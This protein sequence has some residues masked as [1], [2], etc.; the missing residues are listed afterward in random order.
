[1]VIIDTYNNTMVL[2]TT[3]MGELLYGHLESF[4]SSAEQRECGVVRRTCAP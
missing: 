4:F 2:N 1:M 3:E